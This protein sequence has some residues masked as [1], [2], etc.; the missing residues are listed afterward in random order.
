MN[1]VRGANFSLTDT[2]FHKNAVALCTH[3]KSHL[4]DDLADFIAS[5]TK[6]KR[7]RIEAIIDLEEW[8]REL[9]EIDENMSKSRKRHEDLIEKAVKRQRTSY[10]SYRPTNPSSASSSSSYRSSNDTTSS[11]AVLSINPSARSSGSNF[12]KFSWLL[13]T[14]VNIPPGYCFPPKLTET[15]RELLR[16]YLGCRVCRQLFADHPLPCNVLPPDASSY[17]PITQELVDQ[18]L[19]SRKSSVAAVEPGNDSLS[20]SD[21]F[22]PLMSVGAV[23]PSASIPFNL[24]NGSF[25]TD[26]E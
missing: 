14:K 8:L 26:E 17:V 23:I 4:S 6:N 5:L 19:A 1:G 15:E 2:R 13:R 3:L 18:L 16:K 7:D 21:E 24:G 25:S 11:S 9:T 12:P 22:T 20:A 10:N